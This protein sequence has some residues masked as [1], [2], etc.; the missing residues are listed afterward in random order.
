[1]TLKAVVGLD[2]SLPLPI[3]I[4]KTEANLGGSGVSSLYYVG[5]VNKT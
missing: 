4:D 2:I 3:R 1:M 5:V